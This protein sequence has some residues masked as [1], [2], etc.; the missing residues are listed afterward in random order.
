MDE[1]AF[2]RLAE[3]NVVRQ[4]EIER[5]EK[6]ERLKA[7]RNSKRNNVILLLALM[8]VAGVIA[9]VPF[10]YGDLSR[11]PHEAATERQIM[12][13][14][15]PGHAMSW[16]QDT[17]DYM[18]DKIWDGGDQFSGSFTEDIFLIG[19]PIPIEGI[20]TI[21]VDVRLISYRTDGA[22]TGYRVAL[23]PGTCLD[24]MG[25][26]MDSLDDKYV[27]TSEQ[28]MLIG[29]VTEIE[30]EV[31]AGR[32]CFTFE[33][34]VQPDP[35]GFKA[36]IDAEITPHWN[37]PLL[38]PLW[39]ILGTLAGF[40]AIGAHK[41][42]KAWKAVAQPE[43]P[44]KKTTE[45]EVLEEAEDERV[46]VSGDAD[47]EDSELDPLALQGETG[48]STT[49]GESPTDSPPEAEA[50]SEQPDQS[51][52]PAAVE[53]QPA[54]ATAQPEA[55]AAQPAAAAQPQYTD[56]EL[57]ALGWTDQQIEWHRQAEAMQGNQ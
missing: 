8:A 11:N 1:G 17:I 12:D 19:Y 47:S 13:R 4:A 15:D 25:Q 43:S 49:V 29:T 14:N 48:E 21:N 55:V 27:F 3:Q 36:T 33:Y 34:D 2:E 6:A 50:T 54:A 38:A 9:F 45:D 42:G 41:A 46:A 26:S 30:F 40:A 22:G 51:M 56:E 52:Q 24:T 32:Y 5:R 20:T 31:P 18:A 57:R 35:S 44:D 23:F 16:D 10:T 7:N 53:A 28:S 39:I 37:Q